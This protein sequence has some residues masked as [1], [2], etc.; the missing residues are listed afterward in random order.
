MPYKFSTEEYAD[1]VFVYGVCDGN[2]TA[3]ATEYH[4]RYPNRRIPSPKSI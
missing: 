2:A 3:A 4:R 1:I